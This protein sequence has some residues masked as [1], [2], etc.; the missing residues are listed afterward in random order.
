MPLQCCFI[1]ISIHQ[2]SRKNV[3]IDVAYE[4]TKSSTNL[5]NEH[6]QT[7]KAHYIHYLLPYEDKF[8]R[9]RSDP[10]ANNSHLPSAITTLPSNSEP[11]NIDLSTMTYKNLFQSNSKVLPYN[12]TATPIMQQQTFP[13]ATPSSQGY[14]TTPPIQHP[15]YR[16]SPGY[17]QSSAGY[18]GYPQGTPRIPGYPSGHSAYSNH[19]YSNVQ[20]PASQMS[21]Y[22]NGMVPPSRY[23]NFPRNVVPPDAMLGQFN[24][25]AAINKQLQQDTQSQAMFANYQQ[26]GQQHPPEFLYQQQQSTSM[27]S[28]QMDKRN[29]MHGT[30][31]LFSVHR[32]M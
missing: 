11:R 29:S 32:N 5:T 14:P 15:S 8:G 4:L 9:V 27:S 21:A 18:T 20:G 26:Q 17:T 1:M 31:C 22:H 3:W 10:V 25:A 7:L 19:Q 16:N 30:V 13:N 6:L 23:P 12:Q 24:R 2:V 28:L